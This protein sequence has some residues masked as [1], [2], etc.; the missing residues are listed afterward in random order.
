MKLVVGLGNPGRDYEGT[1]HNVGFDTVDKV[2]ERWAIRW[3][4]WKSIV[5]VAT[6]GDREAILAK[7]KTFMNLSGE[8]V[9]RIS[10]FHKVQPS[11]ILVIVDEAQLP[12]GRLR[13]RASGSAGG[14]N[15]LKS[16]I[17][18]VGQE[19]PRLRIGIGRGDPQWDLSDHVLASFRSDEREII[20]EAIDRAAD[21]VE[22][23]LEDGLAVAM[24]RFNRAEDRGNEES[25]Q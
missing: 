9:A 7:P 22:T 4:L 20:R 17:Q 3:R 12:L 18:Y 2:A 10:A 24:N 25:V 6:A 8:A 5:E 16:V 14:H 19:F 1:R 11:E 13:L 15:G 21:A 23:F